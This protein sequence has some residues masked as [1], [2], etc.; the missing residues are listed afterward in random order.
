MKISMFIATTT[1]KAEKKEENNIN[2][3]RCKKI[4]IILVNAVNKC[5]VWGLSL[6]YVIVTKKIIYNIIFRKH[7]NIRLQ[8]NIFCFSRKWLISLKL[9]ENNFYFSLNYVIV[10]IPPKLRKI[11]ECME[12]KTTTSHRLRLNL[13]IGMSSFPVNC[14]KAIWHVETV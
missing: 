14:G 5:E 13:V 2:Y 9:F 4:F 3:N 12:Y 6:K 1:Q 7:E 8:F 11:L 10:I